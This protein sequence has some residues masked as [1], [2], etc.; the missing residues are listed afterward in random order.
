[1]S[2]QDFKRITVVAEGLGWPRFHRN[3]LIMF[4]HDSLC[5]VVEDTE[6]MWS[7]RESGTHMIRRCDVT[8]LLERGIA[9]VGAA[10]CDIVTGR[11]APEAKTY[12]G[13]DGQLTEVT[14]DGDLVWDIIRGWAEAAPERF[15]YTIGRFMGVKR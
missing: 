12:H 11:L 14:G 7:I 6:F 15:K 10:W 9:N 5:K 8:V 4:D 2:T 3:D 1:M 13:K